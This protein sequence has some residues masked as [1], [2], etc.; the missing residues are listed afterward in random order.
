MLKM[1]ISSNL[2]PVHNPP[3]SGKAMQ[4]RFDLVRIIVEVNNPGEIAKVVPAPL[5]YKTNEVIICLNKVREYQGPLAEAAAG[6]DWHEIMLQ[7]PVDYKGR[8]LVYNCEGFINN[9]YMLLVNREIFG[10]PKILTE[11][12]I[13]K[14]DNDLQ[15][16][17]YHYK[18]N[19]EICSISFKAERKG[20]KDDVGQKGK[21][22][23]LKN[24]PS[25]VVGKAPEVQEMVMINYKKLQVNDLYVG[26]GEIELH[27]Y[28]PPYLIS[29]GIMKIKKALLL[30][31]ELEIE[32][33][34]VVF[35]Y[36][37]IFSKIKKSIKRLF[38]TGS[39]S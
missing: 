5:S 26:R 30:D 31:L 9:P 3:S 25:P 2:I 20:T 23:N 12:D 27:A 1:N 8:Y 38:K 18:S 15:G 29:A 22:L 21:I 36:Q 37:N 19:K 17:A 13:D 39:N 11:I 7:I 6:L 35:N 4:C 28:A 33:G 32:G 34:Q 14:K 10:Y 24:I 16:R